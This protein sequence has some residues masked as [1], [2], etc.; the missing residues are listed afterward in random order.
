[1]KKI[2]FYKTDSGKSPVQEFID[3]LSDKQAKKV[4]WVLRLVRDLEITPTK[5]FKKLINSGDIWEVRVQMG[6][7]IFRFLG[8]YDGSQLIILTNG[9]QKKSQKT[10]KREIELAK[11]RKQRY[12]RRRK[13]D[14]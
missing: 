10:P 1:M 13:R 4:A 9:F 8:F 14:G 3:S 2:I 11:N 12:L 5:Y 7:N 6:R